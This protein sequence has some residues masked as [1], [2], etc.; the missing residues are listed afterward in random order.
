MTAYEESPYERAETPDEATRGDAL[1][2]PLSR[3][4]TGRP[5]PPV[6]YFARIGNIVKI[7]TTTN[8]TSRMRSMYVSLENVLAV[9]PG[10]REEESAYHKRFK[11]SRVEDTHGREL[12]HLD[13]QLRRFLRLG[14][15]N[16]QAD[17]LRTKARQMGRR[18]PGAPQRK[19]FLPVDVAIPVG[20]FA[21]NDAPPVMREVPSYVMEVLWRLLAKPE[22][23]TATYVAAAIG[24]SKTVA[25]EYLTTL[26]DQNMATLTGGG[27]GARW[28]RT[29]PPEEQAS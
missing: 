5:H 16:P 1:M 11:A 4:L 20:P 7:G 24:T 21:A 14:P 22:G 10:G 9:V 28:R 23:T 25:W 13:P 12:F 18:R 26:R 2:I 8:L 6:V 19:Q 27:R 15:E 17:T 3:M 29:K